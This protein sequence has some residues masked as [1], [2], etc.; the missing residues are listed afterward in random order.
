MPDVPH[1]RG[2][3][4]NNDEDTDDLQV[5][6]GASQLPLPLESGVE[7]VDAAEPTDRGRDDSAGAAFRGRE[8]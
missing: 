5:V 1:M 2:E 3:I 6:K 4:D 8:Q 7:A